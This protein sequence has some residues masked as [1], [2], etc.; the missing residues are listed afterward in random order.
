MLWGAVFCAVEFFLCF[1]VLK[2]ESNAPAL[3]RRQWLETR[4]LNDDVP[5]MI[6]RAALGHHS[7]CFD[8]RFSYD[9]GKRE[10]DEEVAPRRRVEMIRMSSNCVTIL[11]L[12][13]MPRTQVEIL[14]TM[15][16]CSTLGEDDFLM[17]CCKVNSPLL[18][19]GFLQ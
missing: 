13:S 5:S 18:G 12:V 19:S 10:Y 2:T 7:R 17:H 1:A 16:L 3:L 8:E 14:P 11:E 6:L 9:L 15:V 4:Q